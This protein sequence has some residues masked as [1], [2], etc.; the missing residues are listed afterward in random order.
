MSKIRVLILV[1]VLA[2]IALLGLRFM[3]PS[4]QSLTESSQPQIP[5][6]SDLQL[7]KWHE[8]TSPSGSFKVLL[9]TLPQHAT[10]RLDDP[11]TKEKRQY[12]MYVSEKDNGTIFMISIITL[13]DQKEAKLDESMLSSVMSDMLA[14]NPENK[15]KLMQMGTYKQF[16]AIDFSIENNQLSIDGKAFIEGQT[17]Y[18]LT[19]VGKIN[20]YMKQEFDF[21]VNS[22]ELLKSNPI[23]EKKP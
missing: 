11:K 9:P 15:V 14:T 3:T 17:L 23:I 20:Q 4:N 8:F 12:D 22:F 7:Q 18:L 1:A 6:I 21:F 10:E 2:I 5:A 16:P 13:L 19:S